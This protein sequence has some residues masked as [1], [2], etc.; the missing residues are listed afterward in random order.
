MSSVM[1]VQLFK[2]SQCLTALRLGDNKVVAR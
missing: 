2:F 1:K